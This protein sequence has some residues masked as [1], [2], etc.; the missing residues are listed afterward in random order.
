MVEDNFC[1]I[2]CSPEVSMFS[3]NELKHV[4]AGCQMLCLALTMK[5]GQLIDDQQLYNVHTGEPNIIPNTP[6]TVSTST[7]LIAETVFLIATIKGNSIEMMRKTVIEI[8]QC[9]K[10]YKPIL[11]ALAL[12]RAPMRYIISKL[13]TLCTVVNLCSGDR[14]SEITPRT[15][16]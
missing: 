9:G 3:Q 16:Q 14:P 15:Q 5:Y 10:G 8:H 6:K 12:Q 7:T 2:T 13:R 1:G 11:K 4:R